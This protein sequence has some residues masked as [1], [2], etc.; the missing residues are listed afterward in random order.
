L[1]SPE[2]A[3]WCG[4]LCLL[5]SAMRTVPWLQHL[6][7]ALHHRGCKRHISP[8]IS[9]IVDQRVAMMLM[10][11]ATTTVVNQSY[12]IQVGQFVF[13]YIH[14]RSGFYSS[15]SISRAQSGTMTILV[16]ILRN[17]KAD[18][19]APSQPPPTESPGKL[20]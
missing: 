19:T 15:S 11:K 4:H 20:L 3:E 8:S 12:S 9:T 13:I 1:P 17:V 6:T 2:V 7:P 10:F 5:C 16:G 18:G 14:R